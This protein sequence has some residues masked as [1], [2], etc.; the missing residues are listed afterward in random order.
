MTKLQK[1]TDVALR[2]KIRSC[3]HSQTQILLHF[4]DEFDSMVELEV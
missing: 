3:E 4:A 2:P 1:R